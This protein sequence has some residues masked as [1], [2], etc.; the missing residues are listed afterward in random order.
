MS[1]AWHPDSS[2]A[3]GRRGR[4]RCKGR[5][6]RS[7]ARINGTRNNTH[8]LVQSPTSGRSTAQ[9]AASA[10]QGQG[11]R[12]AL[13]IAWRGPHVQAQHD[14]ASSQY[15][16]GRAH[17]HHP[18]GPAVR[19][20]QPPRLAAEWAGRLLVRISGTQQPARPAQAPAGCCCAP[21]SGW[22][23]RCSS[24]R[25]DLDL[26]DLVLPDGGCERLSS[27]LVEPR[28]SCSQAHAGR[29]LRVWCQQQRRHWHPGQQLGIGMSNSSA[30]PCAACTR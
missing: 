28:G 23:R 11:R 7:G 1:I 26:G 21:G 14:V 13:A 19:R 27:I 29:C 9:P 3:S 22:S 12:S 16:H 25:Q 18:V 6:A 4:D 10:V 17:D 30:L 15:P 5:T 2:N 20:L 8:S 24:S